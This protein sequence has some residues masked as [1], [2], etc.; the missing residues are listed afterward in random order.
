MEI[1]TV[2]AAQWQHFVQMLLIAACVCG[3]LGAVA[4]HAIDSFF[5][6]VIELFERR[7]RA[8]ESLAWIELKAAMKQQSASA[9]SAQAGACDRQGEG[10]KAGI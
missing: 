6:R 4:Y 9:P 8:R 10:R 7:R 2:T 1:G 3:F 5:D